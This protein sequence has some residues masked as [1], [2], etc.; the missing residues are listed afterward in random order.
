MN[1][2]SIF[3]IFLFLQVHWK[4]RF[5]FLNGVPNIFIFFI[6]SCIFFPFLMSGIFQN[7]WSSNSDILSSALSN[8]FLQFSILP[9]IRFIEI[10]LCQSFSLFLSHDLYLC[11]ISYSCKAFSPS[12]FQLVKCTLMHVIELI[13]IIL[14]YYLSGNLPV[15]FPLGSVAKE[16]WFYGGLIIPF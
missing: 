10:F 4:Y 11:W 2:F 14:S 12:F 9:F 8:L 15:S 13:K 3:F 6:L 5:S 16:L 1:I 7:T